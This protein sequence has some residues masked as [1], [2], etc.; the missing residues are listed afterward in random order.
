MEEKRVF[1]SEFRFCEILWK[2]E[3]VSS[4]ELVK[5]CRDELGWQKSTT[6]TVIKRLTDRGII[7]SVDAVVTSLISREEIEAEES[8]FVVE[9]RFQGSLPRFL[10]AFTKKQT[11]SKDEIDELQRL[12]DNYKE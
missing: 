10:A 12:I 9:K 1:E 7:Q 6:Y 8:S 3:P 4:G 2:H 11:L 5:L